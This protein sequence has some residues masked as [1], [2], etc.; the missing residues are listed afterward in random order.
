MKISIDALRINGN[1]AST[2]KARADI[3]IHYS[4]GSIIRIYDVRLV[5]GN[6]G[7]FVSMPSIRQGNKFKPTCE[8]LDL[9]L[10]HVLQKDM[11]ARYEQQGGN[12]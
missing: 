8:I 12:W 9:N 4:R 3:T 5:K 11:I 2:L 1:P 6:K 10:M 7:I